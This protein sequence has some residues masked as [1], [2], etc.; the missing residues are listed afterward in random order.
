MILLDAVLSLIAVC[1]PR[2]G[3]RTDGRFYGQLWSG[4]NVGTDGESDE[5]RYFPTALSST[6]TIAGGGGVGD[7]PDR[8]VFRNRSNAL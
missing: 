4:L 6:D 5:F 2:K 1:G 7:A 3:G 8:M